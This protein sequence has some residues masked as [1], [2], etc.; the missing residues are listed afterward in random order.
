MYGS[1]IEIE[2]EQGTEKWKKLR[3]KYITGSY[4]SE[5][6][7]YGK[8]LPKHFYEF[9]KNNKTNDIIID[10]N[11][12][13]KFNLGIKYESYIRYIHYCLINQKI[14][15]CGL[16][17]GNPKMIEYKK[18]AVSPDGLLLNKDG[19]D[20]MYIVCEYKTMINNIYNENSDKCIY[21]IPQEY[22]IQTMQEMYLTGR[23]NTHFLAYCIKTDELICKNIYFSQEFWNWAS[24]KLCLFSDWLYNKKQ[25]P[26]DFNDW[27]N[28][29]NLKDIIKVGPII[30]ENDKYIIPEK[31]EN[32]TDFIFKDIDFTDINF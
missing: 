28:K 30:R 26:K 31:I 1:C 10:D 21:G 19:S 18:L 17:I 7:G 23:T 13:E 11:L 27:S 29:P 4:I 12:Q 5:I 6:L 2:I 22:I 25:L 32:I 8:G 16:F 14:R 3:S 20:N 9:L 15:T 24:P